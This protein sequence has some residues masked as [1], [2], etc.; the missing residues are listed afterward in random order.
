[1]IG[2]RG[3]Y[4]PRK[5]EA[6]DVNKVSVFRFPK[7]ESR[8]Q[9]WLRR[10]P[11]QLLSEDVTDAMVVCEKH[12]EPHFIQREQTCFRPDGMSFT[13]V[14][15]TPVLDPSAVPTIF[16]NTPSYLT[17]PLP[18]KRKAPDDRRA[19][20]AARDDKV[21]ADWLDR[22]C[23]DDFENFAA[24]VS[25]K[26]SDLHGDWVIVNKPDLVLF[27]LLINV[28]TSLCPAVVASF[29]VWRDLRV[30]MF[31]GKEERDRCELSWLLGDE[32]K[33]TRWSQLP[34]ICTHLHNAVNMESTAES[35]VCK[36]SKLFKQLT[37]ATK[38]AGDGDN[39]LSVLRFL[40]EQFSLL[41]AAQKRYS[42]R[43]LVI[44]F[45]LFCVSRTAYKLVRD[46]C[47]V[48]P[49]VSYLRQLSSC[50]NA[51]YT[52]LTGERADCT[53]LKQKCSVLS[54]HE[55]LCVLMMDE[56]YVSPK[57][58]YKGGSL[59]G[60]AMNCVTS[61]SS[62]SSSSN[63]VEA[64]TVQ[65]FMISSVFSKNKDVAALQPV[66]NLDTSFLHDSVMKV[67]RMIENVGYKIVALISDN[68]RINRN[69]FTSLCGGVLYPFTVHPLDS[70]RKLFFM[71]DSV[72]LLKSIRNNW[73][74]QIDQTFCFP[75]ASGSLVKASFAHLKQL[76]DSEKS[77]IVK[78]APSLSFTSLHPNNTQRQNVKLALQVFDEKNVAALTEFGNRFHSQ[79]ATLF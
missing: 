46:T 16:P 2:C 27:V 1:V 23:V 36:I 55:L 43:C 61:S 77:A 69:V 74:N 4:A 30:D 47:L 54:E 14:R 19:E 64:G 7:E 68:N 38:I 5:D 39:K 50:F 28:A 17:S 62:S 58:T 3:N 22:D 9:E 56:I 66:K 75:A 51:D 44:A 35:T 42:P 8:K 59:H 40:S 20:M 34:N 67:L 6:A 15:D 25:E 76:Y 33:L 60:F 65:A 32:G 70:S 71:F 21:L 37:S 45:R 10:I 29:K 63:T 78:L 72:H 48:L 73:I 24:S 18:T 13:C 49:H 12:F 79:R 41:Y 11:Q 31:V 26:T 52:T 57:I 53:Y